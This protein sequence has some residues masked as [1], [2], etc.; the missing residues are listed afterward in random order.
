M[1]TSSPHMDLPALVERTLREIVAPLVE[2]D[3]GLLFFVSSSLAPG[4]SA[5][6][7]RLHLT[8][9]CSGCPGAKSTTHDVI[10]P[11]LR[12][13]GVRGEIDV[14]AGWLVPPGAER[15]VSTPPER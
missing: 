4:S 7:L 14:T 15:I 6:A 12:A 11:A 1:L 9:A 2:A 3:G 5:V 8:G 13:A 10:E